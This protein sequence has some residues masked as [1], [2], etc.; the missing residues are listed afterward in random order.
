MPVQPGTRLGPYQITAQIGMGGMGEVGV[1]ATASGR[2][3][4]S[5]QD[6]VPLVNVS[7]LRCKERGRVA[8]DNNRL[9]HVTLR[10]RID[11]VLS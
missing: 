5:V 8:F 7:L 3:L 6:S 1:A 9:H 2:C 4:P 10:D 11:D